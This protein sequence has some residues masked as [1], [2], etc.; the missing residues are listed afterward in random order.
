M[1]ALCKKAFFSTGTRS[2]V[3]F[4]F[5]IFMHLFLFL[6]VRSALSHSTNLRLLGKTGGPTDAREIAFFPRLAYAGSKTPSVQ[7][8]PVLVPQSKNSSDSTPNSSRSSE[9]PAKGIGQGGSATD[10]GSVLHAYLDAE[11][12]YPSHLKHLGL[13]GVVTVRF[14]VSREGFLEDIEVADSQ[15]PA[16][17]QREALKFLKTLDRVPAPPTHLTQQELHFE[18]PLRYELKT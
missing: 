9:T 15:A 3:F 4:L 16:L 14:Q 12:I 2:G 5:S 8:S 6:Q 17:L 7:H 10:Y 18:L 1:T 11:K 13:S